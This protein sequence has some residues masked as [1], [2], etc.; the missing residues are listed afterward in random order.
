MGKNE[1]FQPHL[2]DTHTKSITQKKK[3]GNTRAARVSRAEK[4]PFLLLRF[5]K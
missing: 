4:F 3:F 1:F 2:W 5:H